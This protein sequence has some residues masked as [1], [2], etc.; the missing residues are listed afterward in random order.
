VSDGRIRLVL[1]QLCERR[2]GRA[3]R[4]SEAAVVSLTAALAAC[5]CPRGLQVR[6]HGAGRCVP[7]TQPAPL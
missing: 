3:A 6:N 4:G 1:A 2:S 5:P 7:H